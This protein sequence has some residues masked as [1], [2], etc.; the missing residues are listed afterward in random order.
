MTVTPQSSS[1]ANFSER[2]SYWQLRTRRIEF[3]RRPLLMG[4]IN[5]TPDSFSDGGQYMGAEQAVEKALYL[6]SHGA[7]LV[8]IGGE[9]TRP[10]SNPV[11]LQQE[12][13]RVVPVIE[14]LRSREDII[15]SVDTS[16]SEVA[17]E[18]LRQGAEIINDV[19]GLCGDE[20]MLPLVAESRAGVCAMH[21][22]G[23][24][25][26]MQNS[27]SYENVVEEVFDFLCT[28]R[29]ALLKAGLAREAICLDPGIG[30][31]KTT[32]HNFELLRRIEIFH[33]LGQPLL[34]GHSRKG[35][36]SKTIEEQI[37]S[38]SVDREAGTLGLSL[39]LATRGVQILRL[40]DP[41]VTRQ[42]LILFA[43]AGGYSR[44]D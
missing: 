22:Q 35:F 32:L 28:R 6:V 37:T 19:T 43:A 16:K 40:H 39:A 41:D 23:T 42:A 1:C 11:S 24:P 12:L 15:I 36:V 31:G 14:R 7:D 10:Y 30:F 3:S 17:K 33:R 27:P 13:D 5:V 44:E 26:T 2:A 34:V 8:D 21:M 18:C 29:D 4:I 9:S 25:Q 38:K 20:A